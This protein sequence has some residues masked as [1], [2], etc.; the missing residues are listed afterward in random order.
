MTT[1]IITNDRYS[2]QPDEVTFTQL[3]EMCKEM[4]FSSNL[5]ERHN[6]IYDSKGEVVATKA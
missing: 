5:I 4:G 3:M 1:Y 6:K 2:N